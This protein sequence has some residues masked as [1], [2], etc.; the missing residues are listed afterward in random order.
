MKHYTKDG[1]TKPQNRIVLYTTQIIEDGL[2]NN[3]EEKFQVINP[4]HE[5]LIE[6]GWVEY[7]E[8]SEEEVANQREVLLLK[9]ILSNTDYK[10]IKCMEAYLCGEELPYDINA[11][12]AER[13]AQRLQI[14]TLENKEI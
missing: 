5:M 13:S 7:I 14:N 3:R 4:P 9:R 10:I 8:P 2:G 1:T 12:H 6:Q 11:L